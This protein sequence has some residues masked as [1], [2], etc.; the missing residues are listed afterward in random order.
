LEV[1]TNAYS[2]E[3]FAP[4]INKGQKFFEDCCSPLTETLS[5]KL[6]SIEKSGE[7]SSSNHL[8]E[9]TK[10]QDVIPLVKKESVTKSDIMVRD[11][12]TSKN[13]KLALRA[14]VMNKNVVRALRRE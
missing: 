3:K 9:Q 7:H 14:D 8:V 5:K 1:D 10:E 2:P 11:K 13:K 12:R 6:A 4:S